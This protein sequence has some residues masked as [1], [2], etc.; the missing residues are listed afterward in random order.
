MPKSLKTAASV[1]TKVF[2]RIVQ[3]LEN[4]HD[5]KR[6]V[7]RNLRSWKGEPGDK[8]PF[9]PSSNA[10]VVRLTPNPQGVDW[11]SPDMQAGSLAVRVELAV[12][13]L[14]VDDVAD[15]WDVVIAALVPHGPSVGGGPSF[16]L[17]LVSLGAE[18][19]EIV[20]SD[21]AYDPRPLDSAEGY[22]YGVGGFHLRVLR[23][24]QP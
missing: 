1:W 22:F 17:D 9:E 24:V 18:T 7:G 6:I 10:P 21:P 3:Q 5:V 2:R 14:C 19:G 20:F 16:G 13:S 12:P 4:D 11:Y 23:T 15:L 8:A